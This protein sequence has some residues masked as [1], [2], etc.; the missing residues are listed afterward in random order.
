MTL[1]IDLT[2]TE[3]ARLVAGAK[4]RESAPEEFLKRLVTDHLPQTA[5]MTFAEI[6][7]P[8]HQYSQEQGETDEELGVFADAE[9]AAYR[10]EHR[11]KL[12]PGAHE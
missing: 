7:A 5:E 12:E 9:V 11:A 2:P 3:E 4:Q 6:L 10:A 8:V 1:T